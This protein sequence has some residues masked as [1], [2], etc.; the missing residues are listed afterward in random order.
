MTAVIDKLYPK[1]SQP[2]PLE[3]FACADDEPFSVRMGVVKGRLS[4]FNRIKALLR[5]RQS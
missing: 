5:L 1:G 4:A 3:Y 2:D